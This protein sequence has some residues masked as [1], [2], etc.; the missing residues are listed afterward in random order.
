MAWGG[1]WER[2]GRTIEAEGSRVP[3]TLKMTAP[4]LGS[5][6]A[7]ATAPCSSHSA[8]ASLAS[9]AK[10]AGTISVALPVLYFSASERLGMGRPL[11]MRWLP[12]TS[13]SGEP[14]HQRFPTNCAP[15]PMPM[16]T[17]PQ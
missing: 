17:A 2:G 9:V 13:S 7:A 3:S 5:T 15:R 16:I 6:T 4:S 12:S 11:D 1:R 8:S 10:K 14:T